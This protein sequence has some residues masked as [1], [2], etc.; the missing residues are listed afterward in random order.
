MSLKKVLYVSLAMILL[1]ISV[2]TGQKLAFKKI[3]KEFDPEKM[4][5]LEDSLKAIAARSPFVVSILVDKNFAQSELTGFVVDSTGYILTAAHGYFHE[6]RPIMIYFQ[7]GLALRARLAGEIQVEDVALLSVDALLNF[8]VATFAKTE[9]L[10]EK[11]NQSLLDYEVSPEKHMVVMKCAGSE[12]EKEVVRVLVGI[13]RKRE[14][15][16]PD[17]EIEQRSGNYRGCSGAPALNLKGEVVTMIQTNVGQSLFGPNADRLK[18]I[19]EILM[20]RDSL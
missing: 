13:L 18:I 12:R 6:N 10:I 4:L 9:H 1:I 15:A 7:N 2:K 11:R 3:S 5:R 16:G 17:F 14:L 8:E 19:S 20:A